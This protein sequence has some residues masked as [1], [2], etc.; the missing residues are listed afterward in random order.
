VGVKKHW[1]FCFGGQRRGEITRAN[2][3]DS[4]PPC[5]E[6]RL[7]MDADDVVEERRRVQGLP[8]LAGQ[9]IVLHDLKK[10]YPPQGGKTAKVRPPNASSQ[11]P[12]LLSRELCFHPSEPFSELSFSRR[13]VAL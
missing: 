5:D 4:A 13:R 12:I 1:L 7:S 11:L 9:S 3:V 10:V 2:K 6:A 8:T